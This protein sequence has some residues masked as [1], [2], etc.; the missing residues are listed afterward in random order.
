MALIWTTAGKEQRT[1]RVA[2]TVVLGPPFDLVGSGFVAS[3]Q[4]FA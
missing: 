2:V 3:S 1:R 4:V